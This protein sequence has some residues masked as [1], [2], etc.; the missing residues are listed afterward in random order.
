MAKNKPGLLTRTNQMH[1]QGDGHGQPV[2]EKGLQ[3]DPD[4]QGTD[5]IA[6]GNDSH[7]KSRV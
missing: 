7:S 4:C 1:G 3:F 5:S 2:D 6:G